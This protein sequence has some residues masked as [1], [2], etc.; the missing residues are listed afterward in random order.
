[1][2]LRE[3]W[4][5]ERQKLYELGH[6]EWPK[7][8]SLA[9]YIHDN[10]KEE[11]YGTRYVLEDTDGYIR[12][13]LMLLRLRPY[14][15]GIGSVVVEP[16]FRRQGLGSSLI[17]QCMDKHSDAAFMLYSEIGS[18]YYEKLGFQVLPA[19]YQRYSHGLCMVRAE[20]CL[21]NRILKEPIPDY[22]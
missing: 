10:Q 21:W 17:R 18:A 12:A 19:P 3:A 15:Y 16:N 13:S 20:Q 7:G 22:F 8:R 2:L 4:P 11:A 6:Q 14:L 1:M 9:Q 5:E